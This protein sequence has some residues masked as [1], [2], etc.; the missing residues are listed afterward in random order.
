[1][2]TLPRSKLFKKKPV[3]KLQLS[4]I[5]AKKNLELS[6]DYDSSGSDSD[7][8]FDGDSDHPLTYAKGNYLKISINDVLYLSI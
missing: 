8:W 3:K 7:E 1:M 2:P 5:I 4:Q 6:D